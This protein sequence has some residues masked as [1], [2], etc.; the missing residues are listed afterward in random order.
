[1]IQNFLLWFMNVILFSNFRV[2][3]TSFLSLAL[4]TLYRLPWTTI[5]SYASK[6]YVIGGTHF[7][8]QTFG[9]WEPDGVGCFSCQSFS[10]ANGTLADV[11]TVNCD[12]AATYDHKLFLYQQRMDTSWYLLELGATQ[13]ACRRKQPRIG[14]H[15]LMRPAK[16]RLKL[17]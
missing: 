6:L 11:L 3:L 4:I 16:C 12:V 8:A 15:T 10:S 2:L 1:M 14:S 7:D 17:K 9:R 5:I 13:L